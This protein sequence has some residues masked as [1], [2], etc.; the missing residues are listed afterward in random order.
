V[1]NYT[2][3]SNKVGKF[4]FRGQVKYEGNHLSS[5]E[6]IYGGYWY[7]SIKDI[8]YIHYEE[9]DSYGNICRVLDVECKEE[10]IGRYT[11]LKDK[12]GVEIYEDDILNMLDHLGNLIDTFKIIWNEEE[13]S[14]QIVTL[15][16]NHI[17]FDAKCWLNNCEVIGNIYDT[18]ERESA[19]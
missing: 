8:H 14:Y 9:I 15:K 16:N 12:N 19:E 17:S 18:K 5:G 6:W 3:G 7:D 10:T 13:I 11:G 2:I 1:N 4:I